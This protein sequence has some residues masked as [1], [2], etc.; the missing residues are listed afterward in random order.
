MI[1]EH[2]YLHSITHT[3]MSLFF[4][5]AK[6][7]LIALALLTRTTTKT[8]RVQVERGE[9]CSSKWCVFE[10]DLHHY[11]YTSMEVDLAPKN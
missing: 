7:S 1:R 2:D 10:R 8:K 5:G 9:V 11:I 4:Q 3:K 6:P